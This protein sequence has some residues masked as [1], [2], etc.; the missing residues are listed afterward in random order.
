MTVASAE[1]GAAAATRT[2]MKAAAAMWRI[3]LLKKIMVVLWV[4]LE[5][6]WSGRTAA[7]QESKRMMIVVRNCRLGRVKFHGG[8]AAR[9]RA[10]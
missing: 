8:G 2:T 7:G 1:A 5:D 10:Q 9:A 3:F 4:D 6:C